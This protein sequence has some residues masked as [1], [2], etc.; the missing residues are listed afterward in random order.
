MIYK[1]SYFS[2]IFFLTMDSLAMN[3][4]LIR[5]IDLH[6]KKE[7]Y[8][9]YDFPVFSIFSIVYLCIIVKCHINSLSFRKF[10][11]TFLF[12]ILVT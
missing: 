5:L 1:V 2:R 6:R 3:L 12:S 9:V 4:K 11:C 8:I 7:S 10:L